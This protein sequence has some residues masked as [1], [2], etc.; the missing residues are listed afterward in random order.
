[1][2]D[3]FNYLIVPLQ[4]C[5]CVSQLF[6]KQTSPTPAK[7]LTLQIS[8]CIPRT[9]SHRAPQAAQVNG[10][11]GCSPIPGSELESSPFLR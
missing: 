1:M 11:C 7:I 5:L 4:N 9:T 10:N 6:P 3:I 2:W 8:V